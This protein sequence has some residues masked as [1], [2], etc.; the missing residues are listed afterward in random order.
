MMPTCH[1]FQLN[2][3]ITFIF[4]LKLFL[5]N[6][7]NEQNMSSILTLFVSDKHYASYQKR[8]ITLALILFG[9]CAE[10]SHKYYFGASTIRKHFKV[11]HNEAVMKSIEL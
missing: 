8:H 2:A 10:S 3:P 5:L 6:L 7:Y 9:E 11:A 4:Q 1:F